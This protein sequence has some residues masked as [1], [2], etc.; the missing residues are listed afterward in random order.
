MTIM[1]YTIM[2]TCP[3]FS[4]RIIRALSLQSQ[5]SAHLTKIETETDPGHGVTGDIAGIEFYADGNQPYGRQNEPGRQRQA[6]GIA[7][8]G[9]LT[10]L[11]QRQTG[12][13][14]QFK[15]IIAF[16]PPIHKAESGELKGFIQGIN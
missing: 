5:K 16:Y 7:F 15:K 3:A 14:S 9:T 1:G 2:Q 4:S 8:F 12:G 6:K 11:Y 10:Q 13:K